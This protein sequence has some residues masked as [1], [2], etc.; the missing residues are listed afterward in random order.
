MKLEHHKLSAVY[1]QN[2]HISCTYYDNH[3]Y[4]GEMAEMYACIGF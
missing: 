1:V 2:F 3:V 4:V